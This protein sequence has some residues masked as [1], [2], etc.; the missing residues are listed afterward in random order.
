MSPTARLSLLSAMRWFPVG[1]VVP[2]LVLLLG[3]RGLPLNQVGQIMAVYG[4]VTLL[5][6]LP[7]GGLADSWGRRPVIVASALMH[8]VPLV[9]LALLGS[10]PMILL[11]VAA[12]GAARALSSGP[13]ESWFVD[14]IH[15]G[16]TRHRPRHS[17]GGSG[18]RPDL[19][20]PWR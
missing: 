14:S 9:M 10:L 6:E 7:T 2:V 11:A 1:L 4:V 5:L 12:L 18:P 17:G 3:A 20:S 16:P 13:L 15:G 8:A 19:G